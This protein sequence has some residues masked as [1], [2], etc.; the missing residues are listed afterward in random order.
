MSHLTSLNPRPLS[1]KSL[2]STQL[3][4]P[5]YF[6]PQRGIR[7]QEHCI[8]LLPALVFICH[9]CLWD[10]S[11]LSQRPS[12][13]R[14]EFRPKQAVNIHWTE[15]YGLPVGNVTQF[16]NLG[17][18]LQC[19]Q[20]SLPWQEPHWPYWSLLSGDQGFSEENCKDQAVCVTPVTHLRGLTTFA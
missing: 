9:H 15:Q 11:N 8:S 3:S 14:S 16:E 5:P 12:A 6:F 20:F 13:P 10:S 19:S 7:S 2:L 4:P 17:C 1:V 18:A